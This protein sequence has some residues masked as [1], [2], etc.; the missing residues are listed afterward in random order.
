MADY[1]NLTAEE[2]RAT[3]E[4][5]DYDTLTTE[6]LWDMRQSLETEKNNFA[7]NEKNQPAYNILATL[8]K[9]RLEAL[10]PEDLEKMSPYELDSIKGLIAA[11]ANSDM[12]KFDGKNG[13]LMDKI[14]QLQSVENTVTSEPVGTAEAKPVENVS[15]PQATVTELADINNEKSPINKYNALEVMKKLN[16]LQPSELATLRRALNARPNEQTVA[17]GIALD[18]HILSQAEK[19]AN[20]KESVVGI[21]EAYAFSELLELVKQYPNSNKVKENTQ[22][23]D[24]A[25]KQI[26]QEITAFEE[27]YGLD[28]DNLQAPEI[29]EQNIA[30]LNGMPSDGQIFALELRPEKLQAPTDL[31]D[32]VGIIESAE[33]SKSVPELS[34]LA[35]ALQCKDLDEDRRKKLLEMAAT[36]VKSTFALEHKDFKN[37]EY[38]LNAV[39]ASPQALKDSVIKN[40]EQL[41]ADARAAYKLQAPVKDKEFQDIYNVLNSLQIKGELKAFGRK[42]VDQNTKDS[43]LDLFREQIRRETEIYLANTSRNGI[44]TEDFKQEY[45]DRLRNNLVQLVYA[46]KVSKGQISEKDFGKMFDEMAAAAKDKK[47]I[48]INQE[49]IIGWQAAKTN[50]LE[51][52][53]KVEGKKPGY[54][55]PAKAFSSRVKNL[56]DKLSKKYGAIYSVLKTAAKS[57]GWGTAYSLAGATMGPAGVAMVAT[58]SFANTSWNYFK[59]YKKARNEAMVKGEK[60]D[61]LWNYMKKNKLKTAGVF[62]GAA[63]VAIGIG[64]L[65]ANAAVHAARAG[66][67]MAL[68]AAGAVNQ[69]ANAYKNTKGSKGQK[70]WAATKAIAVSGAAFAAAVMVGKG[71]N[72][73]ATE[74]YADT[75]DNTSNPTTNNVNNAATSQPEITPEQP[76]ITEPVAE[77]P[78][79]QNIS[80][81]EA[82]QEQPQEVDWKQ[83][84]QDELS[85]GIDKPNA[86]GPEIPLRPDENTGGETPAPASAENTGGEATA[87]AEAVA[88]DVNN[89]TDEQAHDI[90]MLFLRDPR[91]ANAILGQQ[92]N[93]WMN[94]RELQESWDN[95]NITPEQKAEL[96]KF[97]GE[98]FDERGNF[99]GQDAEKMEAEAKAYSSAHNIAGNEVASNESAAQNAE[100]SARNNEPLPEMNSLTAK[101]ETMEQAGLPKTASAEQQK[102]SDFEIKKIKINDDGTAKIV[103]TENGSRTTIKTDAANLDE[104]LQGYDKLKFHNNGDISVNET[105]GDMKVS[106]TL[107]ED[108][109]ITNGNVGG[110]T[111]EEA[112]IIDKSGN[113]D[114]SEPIK[115]HEQLVAGKEATES[116]IDKLKNLSGRGAGGSHN[117]NTD[118]PVVTKVVLNSNNNTRG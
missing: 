3:L 107:S 65:G 14:S 55:A 92:G 118:K 62:M 97:A 70:L 22:I 117:V 13:E 94:S 103:G 5:V 48:K 38:L 67:G 110:T 17:A 15:A 69:G 2:V 68:A 43:D 63:T 40:K 75:P 56:D 33:A 114:T 36:R 72:G 47:P 54:E 46:D 85:Q 52:A 116:T 35:G 20:G 53:V 24:T 95:G 83:T 89:L 60:P 109:K 28:K 105:R 71:I 108:G 96:V 39:K 66:S 76:Q 64:G 16:T 6:N 19:C 8:A 73:I 7:E 113:V 93:D 115:H 31:Q 51:S 29:V 37:F 34:V 1:K 18:E 9:E 80:A 77:A 84:I 100:N 41:L 4:T 61:N 90:K 87:P 57:A 49:S 59:D 91:D 82:E 102:E 11:Y 12:G 21:E 74:A 30:K 88:I 42:T 78:A 99:V 27:T 45:A 101:A 81:P 23:L 50:R 112:K 58:A 44:S 98:R 26:K 106:Y 25:L 79:P 10:S 86:D 111:F 32:V 104:S